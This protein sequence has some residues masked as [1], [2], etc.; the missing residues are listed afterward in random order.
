MP[1][2]KAAL[3]DALQIGA[4]EMTSQITNGMIVAPVVKGGPTNKESKKSGNGKGARV[5]KRKDRDTKLRELAAELA[6]AKGGKRSSAQ[7]D[8]QQHSEGLA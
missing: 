7:A 6:P 1:R 8:S 4:E 3:S 5:A 2:T